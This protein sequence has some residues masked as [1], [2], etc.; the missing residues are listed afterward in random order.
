MSSGVIFFIWVL[1]FV[2][3]VAAYAYW[4][5]YGACSRAIREFYAEDDDDDES[6]RGE[7]ICTE[8]GR[9]KR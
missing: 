4:I 1:L 3:S 5:T 2:F 9:A 6:P 8:C 7:T